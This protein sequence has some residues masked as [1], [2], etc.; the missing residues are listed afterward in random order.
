[1]SIVM[2]MVSCGKGE[3]VVE[4]GCVIFD[5]L[6]STLYM[7]ILLLLFTIYII[8]LHILALS[9]VLRPAH[10]PRLTPQQNY[11]LST[12]SSQYPKAPNNQLYIYILNKQGSIKYQ[13][14]QFTKEH[15]YTIMP[16]LCI[17]PSAS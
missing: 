7:T 4:C 9:L 15:L 14:T 11:V 13:T 17:F 2:V 3:G 5:L 6:V 10:E 16:N 1:M 8:H 12:K